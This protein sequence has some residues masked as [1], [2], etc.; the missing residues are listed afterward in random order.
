LEVN[1][2]FAAKRARQQG[3]KKFPLP[4]YE[5]ELCQMIRKQKSSLS[6]VSLKFMKMNAPVYKVGSGLVIGHDSRR[7]TGYP[8][9]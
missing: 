6:C 5:Q 8:A 1:R 9:A 7:K 2:N 3:G 4:G